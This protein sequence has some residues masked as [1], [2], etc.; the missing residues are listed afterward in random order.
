MDSADTASL[1]AMAAQWSLAG[2]KQLLDVLHNIHESLVSRCQETNRALDEMASS[3]DEATIDLQNVNNKFMALSNSQFIESRVYDDDI[4]VTEPTEQPKEPQKPEDPTVEL[5]KIKEGLKVLEDMHEP[6]HILHDTDSESDTEDEDVGRLILKPKDLYADRPLPYIIG[7]TA[8]KSKWH[9][10]LLP[11]DSDT[12]SSVSRPDREVEQYSDSEPEITNIQ[13]DK[14]DLINDRTVSTTSSEMASEQDISPVKPSPADV[15]AELA[16]RLGGQMPPRI[17]DPE[18]ECTHANLTSRKVYRPEKPVIGTVFADEPP[19]LDTYSDEESQEDDIFAELHKGKPYMR[20]NTEHNRVTEDLFGGLDRRKTDDDIFNENNQPIKPATHDRYGNAVES[21]PEM[22]VDTPQP[23]TINQETP[24]SPTVS[25]VKKPVGGISLFGT[26]KGTEIGAAIMKRNRKRSSTDDETESEEISQNVKDKPELKKERDI[27]DDLFAKSIK[28]QKKVEKNI[29]NVEKERKEIKKL[30]LFN[31][32]LF[33]DIDDIFSTNI[34]KVKEPSKNKM[35]LFDD[36]DDLFSDIAVVKSTEQEVKSSKNIFDSEDDLFSDRTV[37]KTIL[38]NHNNNAQNASEINSQKVEQSKIFDDNSDS[39]LFNTESVIIPTTDLNLSSNDS[40]DRKIIKTHINKPTSLIP[41]NTKL[42][43][44][45]NLLFDDEEGDDLFSPK[46]A[47][48]INSPNR[49]IESID[50][51]NANIKNNIIKENILKK[52]EHYKNWEFNDSTV[53]D[54]NTH[55]EDEKFIEIE[56]NNEQIISKSDKIRNLESNQP[57]LAENVWDD[58]FTKPNQLPNNKSLPVTSSKL[59]DDDE[60]DNLFN[61][62][63]TKEK[64]F[65]SKEINEQENVWSDELKEPLNTGSKETV[66]VIT[67]SENKQTQRDILNEFDSNLSKINSS[68]GMLIGIKNEKNNTETQI[69]DNDVSQNIHDNNEIF[70]ESRTQDQHS[71]NQENKCFPVNNKESPLKNSEV[72]EQF[73]SNIVE[74]KQR[75]FTPDTNLNTSKISDDADNSFIK[76]RDFN[77]NTTEGASFTQQENL[78]VEKPD[79]F[80]DIFS[81]P[82]EFEKPKEPKRSKNVNA[83]FDDD[84]DDEALFFKKSDSTLDEKPDVMSPLSENRLFGLFHDEPPAMDIDFVPNTNK[85][86]DDNLFNEVPS[87]SNVENPV[88]TEAKIENLKN[89]E[90]SEIPKL[91]AETEVKKSVGKLKTINFNIDVSALLPGASPK[92]V[93]GVEQT[94][95]QSISIKGE[96]NVNNKNCAVEDVD[97]KL[98]KSVSFEGDPKSIVL[99]NKLSKERARIQVKRRPSSRRARKEAVRKSAIDFGEDST[100]NS[101]SIEEP[102]KT[103][104]LDVDNENLKIGDSSSDSKIDNTNSSLQ[105]NIEKKAPEVVKSKVVYVLHDEDIF[106]NIDTNQRIQSDKVLN[107]VSDNDLF[108]NKKDEV[109]FIEKTHKQN[110]A[111]SSSHIQSETDIRN[112]AIDTSTDTKSLT[113]VRE[114]LGTKN[115]Q[116]E[117]MNANMYGVHKPKET[118][119]KDKAATKVKKSIFDDLSDDEDELFNKSKSKPKDIFDSDSE[120]ELFG[121]K[122]VKEKKKFEGKKTLFSDDEDDELFGVKTINTTDIPVQLARQ[123]TKEVVS[124]PTEPVFEDPLSLLGDDD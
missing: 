22:F 112:K 59:F 76:N 122:D 17:P 30:D 84:S 83:L 81:E 52:E 123:A 68:I 121:K 41:K 38:E 10:G 58:L 97:P 11:D 7:S 9:A 47:I 34:T 25:T 72:N 115:N 95:G 55:G 21:D 124:K 8:W 23:K 31:D 104:N 32:D 101:T 42:V 91:S 82:P 113:G 69:Y 70:N 44:N 5:E 75:S 87:D 60:D 78:L 105:H 107:L 103:V 94:D 12:D 77:E 51:A 74:Q 53:N 43:V 96:D 18:P 29:E 90:P 64:T 73:I 40:Y 102:P 67:S 35:S 86:L 57:N 109:I 6:L 14:Q 4:D 37:E 33:D 120:G 24:S 110:E 39:D 46:N 20:N 2:D 48:K 1:R 27:F 56:N 15:A 28:E 100:D 3:L 50:K 99:D 71:L 116:I 13:T 36:D 106:T 66:P 85:V 111:N 80:S 45:D 16:R 19:P 98:I 61:T 108:T 62:K 119:D 89:A 117:T 49:T 26:K 65:S 118:T 93:K 63:Q 79:V 114:D 92:K 54:S 88:I